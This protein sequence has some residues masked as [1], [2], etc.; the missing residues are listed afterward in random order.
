MSTVTSN[1][2][3]IQGKKRESEKRSSKK[4]LRNNQIAGVIYSKGK[5]V[6]IY[7]NRNEFDAMIKEINPNS[8]IDIKVDDE[9]YVTFIKEL[10]Y[11][12]GKNA[13]E[14][15][16]FYNV[17]QGKKIKVRVPLEWIGFPVGISKGGLIRRFSNNLFVECN[18]DKIPS[19][20]KVDIASLDIGMALYVRD[21]QVGSDVDILDSSDKAIIGVVKTSKSKS[22]EE[23]TTTEENK[24]EAKEEEAKK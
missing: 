1:N 16:D 20:I 23:A 15:I 18:S 12:P 19:T 9:S 22:A 21:L 14:H 24:T 5:N 4:A 6:P 2:F 7:F 3:L 13:I 17:E 11:F 10:T 8:L